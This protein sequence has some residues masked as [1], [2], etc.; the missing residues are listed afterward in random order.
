VPSPLSFEEAVRIA[1][2]RNPD[3]VALRARVDAVNANPAPGPIEVGAGVDADHRPEATASLDALSL[4]GLGTRRADRALAHARREEARLAHHARAREI[5]GEIAEAFAVERALSSLFEPQTAVDASAYVRAGL[6]GSVAE[7]LAA[8]TQADWDAEVAERAAAK[9]A[10]RL[11]L[12]RLL[13]APPGTVVVPEPPAEP[14]PPLSDAE[15]ATL[16]ATRADVQRRVAAFETADRELRRAVAA[17]KPGILLEPGIAADP[18]SLFGAVRLRIPVGA[19]R[20]VLAADAA[21]EAARAQVDAAILDAVR[22]AGTSRARHEAAGAARSAAERRLSVS[23]ELLRAQKA[24][25]EVETGSVI[26]LLFTA[27]GVV[28][29]AGSHREALL[30]EARARVRA[31]RDVGWPA[32]AAGPQPQPCPPFPPPAAGR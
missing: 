5:A 27:D 28:D 8:A 7:R 6:E 12:A 4:L 11:A 26:E 18:T 31:A 1:V 9:A 25:L 24:R 32:P 29:A 30:E 23:V 22:D 15:P 21:R 17:Q 16:L 19:G 3:L 13:G 14:W 2:E 20:E 10:N